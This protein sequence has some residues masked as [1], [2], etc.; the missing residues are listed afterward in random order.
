MRRR[1][2]QAGEITAC[3]LQCVAAAAIAF[4]GFMSVMY[5]LCVS[6]GST[7]GLIA[8]PA[9]ALLSVGPGTLA[10]AVAGWVRAARKA[11]RK[12]A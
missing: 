2:S 1:T 7:C 5:H 11:R 12:A 4:T 10:A 9:M 8:T 3:A 6:Y